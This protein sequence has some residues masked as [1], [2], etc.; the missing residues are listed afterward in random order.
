MYVFQYVCV[1]DYK[2]YILSPQ[3]QAKGSSKEKSLFSP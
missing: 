1:H 2:M 3:K